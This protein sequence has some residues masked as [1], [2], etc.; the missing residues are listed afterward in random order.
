MQKEILEDFFKAEK[1]IKLDAIE[2]LL[3][4]Y[5]NDGRNRVEKQR[6]QLWQD[7]DETISDKEIINLIR[8]FF[9]EKLILSKWK[10]GFN[11]YKPT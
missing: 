4:L 5:K 1:Q 11:T 7:N 8:K 10:Q 6:F 9:A 2:K 3:P